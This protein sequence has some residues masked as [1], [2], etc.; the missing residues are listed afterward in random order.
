VNFG[1]KTLFFCE[2]HMPPG[3]PAISVAAMTLQLPESRRFW[4]ARHRERGAA[5][6][7]HVD[8]VGG[9]IVRGVDAARLTDRFAPV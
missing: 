3:S 7:A 6:W 4:C 1:G 2:R 9:E 5:R 8:L